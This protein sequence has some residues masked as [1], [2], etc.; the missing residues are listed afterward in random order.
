MTVGTQSEVVDALT[1]RP[2][3]VARAC[4]TVIRFYQLAREGRPSPCRFTP[5]CS[6]Y[7]AEAVQQ[8][9]ALRGSVLGLRRLLRCQPWG[10]QGY[11][12]VPGST[13]ATCLDHPSTPVPQPPSQKAC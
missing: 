11:D 2:S 3:L 9:G 4:L 10:G 6:T 8:H 12:P 13:N 5:S 7:A 1:I